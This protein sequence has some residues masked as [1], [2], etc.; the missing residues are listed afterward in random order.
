MGWLS[1][2][3]NKSMLGQLLVKQ[4]LITEEQLASAIELQ[5]KTGQRLGDIF[6]ELN[7]ITQENIDHALRK[8]RR[9]R[10]AA[11]IAA[12]LLAPLET[13][14]ATA[15]PAVAAAS[16]PV[17][18][19]REKERALQALTEEELGETSA[20]GLSDD[21]VNAVKQAKGNG[22][23]VIGEMS[24]L[25]NPVLGFLEADTSMKNV[26][27]DPSKAAATVN[28]DGSLTLSLPSSIGEIAFNNIRVK[29]TEG[30][31]FGSISIKGIDLT[32]T[33][34]TLGFR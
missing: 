30:S 8:Q 13:Y 17:M 29:G 33:S 28:K 12:S 20:Q 26:V 5:R 32:G 27:Y 25:L 7:L 9:L 3:Q 1:S 19:G 6:A 34:I 10:M 14:A 18:L 11:A 15:L 21:L 23:A 4:K 22:V 2:N 24:K 31:S 16:A